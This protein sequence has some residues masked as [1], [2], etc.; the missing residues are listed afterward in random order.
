MKTNSFHKLSSA[1]MAGNPE[2][3]FQLFKLYFDGDEDLDIPYDPETALK[4]LRKSFAQGY[5]PAIG[6][7]G[8]I[9]IDGGIEDLHD[10]AKGVKLE[11]QAADKGYPA[12]M[13]RAGNYLFMG[14]TQPLD[15]PGQ[16]VDI[17]VDRAIEYWEKAFGKGDLRA[18][19]ALAKATIMGV[20][21][22]KDYKKVIS[23]LERI[24]RE[25]DPE[26]ETLAGTLA[27][28][29]FWMGYLHF[30]GLGVQRLNRAEAYRWF[31][32]ASEGGFLPAEDIL[33]N[34]DDPREA[35]LTWHIPYDYESWSKECFFE[36][37]EEDVVTPETPAR[38]PESLVSQLI[39]KAH[40]GDPEAWYKL[41]L[42]YEKGRGVFQSNYQAIQ[43]YR[44]VIGTIPDAEARIA[45]LEFEKL[46]IHESEEQAI[47]DTI[48]SLENAARRGSKLAQ[49]FMSSL[50]KLS[51]KS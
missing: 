2:A 29:Q 16:Y 40:A 30:Y 14:K 35:L 3:Q 48:S 7:M 18:A 26:D 39:R 12:S 38:E 10:P 27:E 23:Y 28:A 4:W 37:Y 25:A 43:C 47:R 13:V 49:D 8:K 15:S 1:A 20:G 44:R 41:G 9:Y 33:E 45:I 46:R 22:D 5:P 19:L 17:D 42:C 24:L 36:A 50:R 34:D 11:I 21:E 51:K 6:E 31:A 32:K